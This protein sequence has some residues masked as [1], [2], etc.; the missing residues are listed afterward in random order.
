MEGLWYPDFILEAVKSKKRCKSR[1]E[2]PGCCTESRLGE[3]Q[4]QV[5]LR[6]WQWGWRSKGGF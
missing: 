1:R 2:M 3:I 5:E 4:G 6:Q